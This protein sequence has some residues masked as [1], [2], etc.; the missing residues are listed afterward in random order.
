MS[1]I[2]RSI[3]RLLPLR[4]ARLNLSGAPAITGDW[5]I[6]AVPWFDPAG[7]RLAGWRGRFRRLP[8]A[9]QAAP[10][11]AAAGEA[12]RIR[13]LLHELKTPVNAIQGYAEA[14][15]QGLFGPIGHEYRAMSADIA[16]DAARILA[17]PRTQLDEVRAREDELD[18][19][20]VGARED[21][22]T[23]DERLERRRHRG[24]DQ[25][26]ARLRDA[27]EEL[28]GGLRQARGIA[29]VRERRQ[30][31]RDLLRRVEALGRIDAHAQSRDE[32]RDLTFGQSLQ[33]VDE[34]EEWTGFGPHDGPD[35]VVGEQSD[36][37][38]AEPDDA[39]DRRA[40]ALRRTRCHRRRPA[41]RGRGVGAEK[42]APP[43]Q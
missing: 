21:E 20:A 15:Q 8:I 40:A 24:D 42:I 19:L 7:G 33:D 29:H 30:R 3:R 38:V 14:M 1:Q 43:R 37:Q 4:A 26:T 22:A 12:D 35:V 25:Q 6:D 32:R 17:L 13:Q 2:T 36:R 18:L 27:M 39:D 11:S 28:H 16:S 5:Q 23:L 9:A 31:A 34:P 10:P 41:R